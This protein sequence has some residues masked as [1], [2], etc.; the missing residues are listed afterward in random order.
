MT[1]GRDRQ[2]ARRGEIQRARIAGDL[3][4]HGGELGASQPLLHRPEHL[5]G[6]AR[7]DMDDAGP[8]LRSRAAP[9]GIRAAM[10]AQHDAVLHP[11]HR[12][13]SHGAAD[14]AQHETTARRIARLG[15]DLDE[16]RLKRSRNGQRLC[17]RVAV[18]L[19]VLLDLDGQKGMV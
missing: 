4:D 2:P 11:K 13:R 1:L 19:R 16:S 15:E 9:M 7:D 10:V 5:S 12:P 6:I 17:C 18:F 14:L 3:A 8:A